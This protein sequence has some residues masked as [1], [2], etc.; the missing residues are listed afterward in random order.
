M[1]VLTYRFWER[2]DMSFAAEYEKEAAFFAA[3][4]LFLVKFRL[5]SALPPAPAALSSWPGGGFA[6]REDTK[7][8]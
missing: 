3:P 2:K 6:A 4:A 8:C 7:D 5:F 1:A